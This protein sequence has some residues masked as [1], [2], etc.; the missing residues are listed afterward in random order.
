MLPESQAWMGE[1]VGNWIEYLLIS[2]FSEYQVSPVS[3]LSCDNSHCTIT[4][5]NKE[6]PKGFLHHKIY[7]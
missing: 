6:I 3:L 2:G 1:L 5:S 7:Q 4:I